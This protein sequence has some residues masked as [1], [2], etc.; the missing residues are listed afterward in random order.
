MQN[1][2][3]H[4]ALL[5]SPGLGHFIPV[6]ELGKRLVT[7][8]GFSVTVFVVTT[9]NSLSKSQLLKQSPCPDL[10]NI[11]LL[12]PVDVSG[13][14]T[15]A[16][17]IL[18]QLAIMMREALPK[19]RSAIVAM[20]FCPTVLI[21][22][23]FG[24][25][26]MVIAE[27]FNMLKYAFITSTAWFLALTLHMPTIDKV[28]EDNHVKN[29]Q[30]LLIPGC[31]SL[32]FGDT[33]EPILDRNDQMYI[34]YKRMGVDLQK[35]DGIL[36][37]TWQDLEGTTLVALE[38]GKKSG[39]V[40]QVPV[41]PV[42]P[43]VRAVK[44][45]GPKSEM[46]EWLDMQPTESVIY[47][48]FGSGGTLSAKQTT[49]LACGLESS[50]QRFIWVV[51][52]PIENDSAA[53]VFKTNHRT[54]DTPDFLP[55]GFLTRTRK[56]GVVVPMWAPQTEILSHPSVGGFVSHCGWNS[57][58]ESI[59]N[60][61]PMIAWPLYAEQGMNAAMLS[62]DIGVAIRSKS[63]PARE[64]V[65]REEIE[66]MVRTIMDEGDARRARVKTL[67][68]SAEKALSKAGSSYNSL[69]QVA[70]DCESAF[71]YLKAKAQGA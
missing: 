38:D 6:I 40:A 64:L 4:A 28:I 30:A 25:E 45:A 9:D 60:G 48:S 15:P 57:T 10:L 62:E 19:L 16:T 46:L 63:F 22:D 55:D 3:P 14:I 12:P 29:Q 50:G 7:N 31:K 2:K 69:A 5:S 23:L 17:G 21:V 8:H 70:N 32:E 33:F 24:I 1:T 44:P 61:V 20:I 68:S 18:S 47:V 26:A 11:V 49:E 35:F 53:T 54:D 52:P 59:V 39:R 65:V 41:F 27:E 66:T 58:L 13:L 51:R 37:N 67:K 43:L 71:K 34:E 42:G 36:V 56:I